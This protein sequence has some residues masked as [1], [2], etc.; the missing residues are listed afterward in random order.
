[1]LFG[2]SASDPLTYVSSVARFAR[3]SAAGVLDS[4]APRD[5]S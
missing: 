5:Q 1:M 4:G 2:V 3:R